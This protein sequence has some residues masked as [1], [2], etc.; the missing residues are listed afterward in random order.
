MAEQMQAVRIHE[1]GGLDKVVLEEVARP[2]PGPGEV[3][4]ELK[5]AALNHLDIWVARGMPAPPLPHTLGSDGAGIVRALGDGAGGVCVGDEVM[6]DPSVSCGR[7]ERCIAGEH[8]ECDRFGILGESRPGTFAGYVVCPASCCHPK[9]VDM[10]FEDAAALGLTFLTAYRMLFTRAR[11]A[12]GEDVLIHGIGGGVATSA[13]VLAKAAGCR[14]IVTSSSE[15]KLE[16]AREL[17]ADM[18]LNY[19]TV[20]KLGKEVLRLS[21]GRGVDVVVETAGE[22][23]WRD[24]V[25]AARKGGRIVTCGATTGGGPP[26]EIQAIFWKQLTVLGSTMGSRSD[27]RAVARLAATGV[28]RPVRDETFALAEAVRAL[29]H[30]EA[31]EQMGKVVLRVG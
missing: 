25:V 12:P 1:T 17:G 23:T 31:G 8:S 11:L 26:A 20:G 18:A 6:L 7:C 9:P 28:I 21:G 4:V 24:S 10:S 27:F 30:L 13:L 16:R 3:L 29:R 5:A 2:E 22:A 19:R 15:A 14:A